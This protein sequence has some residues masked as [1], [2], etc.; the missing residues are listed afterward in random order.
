MERRPA[1]RCGRWQVAGIGGG[2]PYRLEGEFLE[3][4]PPHKLVHTRKA[5]GAPG[6]STIVTYILEPE[7]N[8][9]RLTLNHTGLVVEETFEKTR[10]GWETSLARLAGILAAE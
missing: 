10:A 6:A 7:G 4:E 5:A 1:C 8:Y 2:Q 9:V 3:I